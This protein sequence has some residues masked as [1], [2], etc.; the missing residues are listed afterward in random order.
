MD[1]KSKRKIKNFKILIFILISLFTI[2][3]CDKITELEESVASKIIQKKMSEG[4]E[5][6]S[7]NNDSSLG[8]IIAYE[9]EFLYESEVKAGNEGYIIMEAI[10]EEEK[11]E[12]TSAEHP[13]NIYNFP[14]IKN[15]NIGQDK[16]LTQIN[17][18]RKNI[19]KYL[20]SVVT[21]EG[22]Y[23]TYISHDNSLTYPIVYRNGPGCCGNDDYDGFLLINVENAYKGDEALRLND[24]IKVTGTPFMHEHTNNVGEKEYYLFLV[25]TSIDR[26]DLKSRGAEMV[27]D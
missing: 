9:S 7:Q 11:V 19:D 10:T 5:T 4:S 22:M 14:Y 8:D 18:I 2:N 23:G 17:T 15:I 27:N 21:V 24:W 1:M 26:L 6:R 20:E 3:A 25:A 13:Y 12:E 16:F